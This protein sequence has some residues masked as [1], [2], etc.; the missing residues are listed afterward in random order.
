M[1]VEGPTSNVLVQRQFKRLRERTLDVGLW[2]LDLSQ[3]SF[4]LRRAAHITR[5]H[6]L[7]IRRSE[8]SRGDFAKH[9][10]EVS[11]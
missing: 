3:E 8:V 2:T 4:E 7:E 5:K 9:I 6:S 1:V 11:G 10:A